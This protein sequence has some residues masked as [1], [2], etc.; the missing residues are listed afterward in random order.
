MVRIQVISGSPVASEPSTKCQK[1]HE[2]AEGHDAD[3]PSRFFWIVS[4]E[5]DQQHDHKYKE[6]EW[7]DGV[8][9]DPVQGRA[10]AATLDQE[11]S[12]CQCQENDSDKNEVGENLFKCTEHDEH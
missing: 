4:A 7:R 6:E 10:F 1:I 8:A 3:A 2:R 11:A 5:Q 9:R 12:H